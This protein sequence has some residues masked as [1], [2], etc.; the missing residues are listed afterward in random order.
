[1][2]ENILLTSGDS[3]QLDAYKADPSGPPKG[4]LVVIQEIFG[5]NSQIRSTVDH[6]AGLGYTAIA[7]ALFDR[8][9]KKIEL[10]YNEDDFALGRETRGK[11]TDDWIT[12]DIGAAVQEVASAGKVSVIGFCFGGYATFV[13]ACTV[14]GISAA[15]PFYGGGIA[16]RLEDMKP[17]CPIQFH[18][19]DKDAAIPLDDLQKI[20]DSLQDSPL[21]VYDD[22]GHG[23]TCDDR[24]SFNPGATERAFERAVAWMDEHAT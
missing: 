1:M 11:I 10:G 17:K 22:S 8:V 9:D 3:H 21:Y 14:D 18:F 15:M 2:G 20:K 23:F 6:F 12:S 16:A 13:A 7:P 4:A 19:G 24:D 5:V